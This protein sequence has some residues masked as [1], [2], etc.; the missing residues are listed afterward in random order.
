M[1]ESILSSCALL[2]VLLS[3]GVYNKLSTAWTLPLASRLNFDINDLLDDS[4]TVLSV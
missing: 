3:T 1:R 2:T 4:P